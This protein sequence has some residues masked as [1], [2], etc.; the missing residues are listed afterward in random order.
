MSNL[1]FQNTLLAHILAPNADEDEELFFSSS[2]SNSKSEEKEGNVSEKLLLNGGYYTMKISPN[3][4]M[5]CFNICA[6]KGDWGIDG[7]TIPTEQFEAKTL[8]E[9]IRMLV[10][11][12]KAAEIQVIP[13]HVSDNTVDRFMMLIVSS[14]EEGDTP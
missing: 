5:H 12:Y 14:M 8:G 10:I 1:L 7:W 11:K 9:C 2:A 4:E 6:C 13:T 3:E